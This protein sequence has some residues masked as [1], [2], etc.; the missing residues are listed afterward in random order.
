MKLK[1]LTIIAFSLLAVSCGN[2]HNHEHSEQADTQQSNDIKKTTEIKISLN[3]GKKWD[4]DFSTFT[5]MQRLENALDHFD[6]VFASPSIEDYKKLGKSLAS[7]NK[8]IISQCKMEGEDHEQLHILLAPMLTN[9]DV[10]Q[11]SNDEVEVKKNITALS[12]SIEKFFEHFEV[13]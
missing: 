6:E 8:D 11:N 5:G 7:I 9:V 13:K 1:N 2:S 3:E 10:I 4:A 12:F